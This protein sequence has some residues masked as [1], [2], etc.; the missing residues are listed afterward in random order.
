ML[1][2]FTTVPFY[3]L[4]HFVALNPFFYRFLCSRVPCRDCDFITDQVRYS[5]VLLVGGYSIDYQVGSGVPSCFLFWRQDLFRGPRLMQVICKQSFLS[6]YAV[7]DS[8]RKLLSDDRWIP[9]LCVLSIRDLNIPAFLPGLFSITSTETR[10]YICSDIPSSGDRTWNR[11]RDY[12]HPCRW[13]CLSL[14]SKATCFNHW[15]CDLGRE[16]I[17]TPKCKCLTKLIRDQQQEGQFTPSCWT[18]GFMVHLAFIG[19]LEPV[20]GW[21]VDCWLLRFC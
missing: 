6:L 17:A 4:H 12:V 11:N 14:L 16:F 3:S 10:L 21:Q 13:N 5:S 19:G 18:L 1:M 8:L 9:A 7:V 2:A 15:D 20:L